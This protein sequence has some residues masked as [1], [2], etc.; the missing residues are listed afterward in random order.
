MTGSPEQN[1][2][3]MPTQ[4]DWLTYA[5]WGRKYGSLAMSGFLP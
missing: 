5:E 3:D 4:K 1:A 2:A